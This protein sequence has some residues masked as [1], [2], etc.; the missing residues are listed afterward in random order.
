MS[1]SY[2]PNKIRP[3]VVALKAFC[4]GSASLACIAVLC[5]SSNVNT[6]GPKVALYTLVQCIF[7]FLE[8]L[9]TAIFNTSEVEDDSFILGDTD[10]YLVYV[11]SVIETFL[12]HIYLPHRRWSLFL[13]LVMIMTGQICRTLAM[14]T[15]GTSFNHYVQREKSSKH[16]LITTG[17]YSYSRH[18]S[19]FGYFWWFIGSQVML[20]NW[21]V[22]VAGAYKLSRFFSQRIAYEEEY[23]ISFFGEE[24]KAYKKNT[25][26]RIPFI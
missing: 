5:C 2:K 14:Y 13:G 4:L 15:A 20:G 22:G 7:H 19:Y 18:P 25:P 10:L 11:L 23:L 3:H 21:F 24:Y 8:F 1:Y 16:K 6:S 12:V 26:V 9:S 17:I